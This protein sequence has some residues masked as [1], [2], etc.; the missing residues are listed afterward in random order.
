MCKEQIKVNLMKTGVIFFV[1]ARMCVEQI[2]CDGSEIEPI[3]N[4]FNPV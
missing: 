3:L 1:S 2:R 4:E